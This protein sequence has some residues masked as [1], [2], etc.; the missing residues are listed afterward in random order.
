V[1]V[2]FCGYMGWEI[3]RYIPLFGVS[4]SQNDED[5]NQDGNEIGRRGEGRRGWWRVE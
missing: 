3:Q 4:D 5:S 1:R 2:H